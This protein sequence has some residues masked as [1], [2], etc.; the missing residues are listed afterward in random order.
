M[1]SWHRLLLN[2]AISYASYIH[3]QCKKYFYHYH[4]H[5]YRKKED[6]FFSLKTNRCLRSGKYRLWLF[7]WHHCISILHLYGSASV[8]LTF[9]CSVMS[10][11]KHTLK[12]AWAWLSGHICI[13]CVSNPSYPDQDVP[14]RACLHVPFLPWSNSISRLMPKSMHYL[15]LRYMSKHIR[16]VKRDK[17]ALWSFSSLRRG[18]CVGRGSGSGRDG[19]AHS[20]W[21]ISFLPVVPW[22]APIKTVPATP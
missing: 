18:V 5:V 22:A 14:W 13:Q 11:L 21:L 17:E 16:P 1:A 9:L 7:L 2:L 19:R 3:V 15:T 8:I 4:H 10:V 12:S 20:S 6:L